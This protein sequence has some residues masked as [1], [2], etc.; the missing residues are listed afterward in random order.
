MDTKAIFDY[1]VV[2]A[3]GASVVGIIFAVKLDPAAVKDV[4]IHVI[5]AAE[6]FASACKRI[7]EAA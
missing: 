6:A 3:F 2:L 1:K 7:N 4:S 5:D